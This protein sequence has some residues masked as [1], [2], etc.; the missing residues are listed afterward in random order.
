MRVS[1]EIQ[2]YISGTSVP[3]LNDKGLLQSHQ[4]ILPSEPLLDAFFGFTLTVQRHLF[5]GENATLA[6]T[7]DLLLPKLMSGEIRLTEAEKAVEAVA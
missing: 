4:V 6:Q 3:N 2:K 7:R 5:S 1:G